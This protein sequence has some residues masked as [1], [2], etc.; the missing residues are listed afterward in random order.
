MC[1]PGVPSARAVDRRIK[2]RS[3]ETPDD[4]RGGLHF[5][6]LFC[7]IVAQSCGVEY[8]IL[9][10]PLDLKHIFPILFASYPVA[11]AVCCWWTCAPRFSLAADSGESWCIA[12]FL[13]WSATCCAGA[14][15]QL[16]SWTIS[17]L[18]ASAGANDD[19]A[20]RLV[21]IGERESGEWNGLHCGM[22][23]AW[24]LGMNLST[25]IL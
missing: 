12:R 9:V 3:A 16:C 13:L 2:R 4:R 24:H 15:H 22:C 11:P 10:S 17:F 18:Q 14:V 1:P 25:Y 19:E 7:R 8:L 23:T 6:A 21:R 20:V 5:E